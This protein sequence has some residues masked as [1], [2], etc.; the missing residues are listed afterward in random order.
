VS[1]KPDAVHYQGRF[2]CALQQALEN[3]GVLVGSLILEMEYQKR[4]NLH[5]TSQR[6]D[7]ILHIPVEYSG[8]ERYN[9]N[10]AVWALKHHRNLREVTED[11]IKLDLMFENLRYPMGFLIIIGSDQHMITSYRGKFKD[12]ILSFAVRLENGVISIKQAYFQG[13]QITVSDISS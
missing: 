8:S 9:S 2:Y 13:N 4:E 12:K 3:A 7:I 1:R 5:Q 11:F 10:F 6:P